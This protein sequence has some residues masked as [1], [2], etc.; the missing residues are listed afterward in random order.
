MGGA[1]GS[2]DRAPD[3]RLR[4]TH[5]FR[6]AKMMGFAKGSTHP[7][8]WLRSFSRPHPTG[9]CMSDVTISG[10]RIRSFVERIENLDTELQELNE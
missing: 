3:D 8:R 2:R 1:N 4:D 10:G 5:R 6:L 7:T 9:R